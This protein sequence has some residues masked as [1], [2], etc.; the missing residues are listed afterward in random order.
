MIVT[1]EFFENNCITYDVKRIAAPSDILFLDIETT[2][3]TPR[4][5]YIYM[6]GLVYFLDNRW[7]Y[8][9][10]FATS[11]A[12]EEVLLKELIHIISTFKVLIHFNGTRF[13]LP[14][15]TNRCEAY[16][17]DINLSALDSH[18]LYKDFKP[19]RFILGTGDCRQKT[20][21]QFIGLNR[22]DK[23]SG[24]EL[25]P[26][27]KHYCSFCD[28]ESF[29][30]LYQH[31]RD[32]LYGMLRLLDIFSVFD[33]F[34]APL[35]ITDVNINSYINF[36]GE[37]AC[38]L[39]ISFESRVT[40]PGRISTNK[41]SVFLTIDGSNGLLRIPV[42]EAKLNYYYKN[43]KDYYY[44]PSENMAVHKSV[45]QFV[46]K[47]FRQK[48]TAD[49][50]YTSKESTYILWDGTLALPTF[51]TDRKSKDKYIE[52]NDE[53]INNKELLAEYTLNIIK[54]LREK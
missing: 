2:G 29:S 9:N 32:D 43:Y 41:S 26:V 46:D 37:S 45:G 15:I 10:L 22:E 54:R 44:L 25:I 12:D 1:D 28:D 49:T 16:G 33:F 50:A 8:K 36:T 4:N 30:L 31:N 48:A 27:Y 3:L 38:E 14:F 47:E 42:I 18:D 19:L 6:V 17:I 11:P 35:S 20:L 7:Y 39:L 21:E 34:N 53:L 52:L 24:G 40:I 23:Y 5:S 51:A 13:D